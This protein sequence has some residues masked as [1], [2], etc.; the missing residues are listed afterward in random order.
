MRRERWTGQFLTGLAALVACTHWATAQAPVS[1]KPAAVVNGEAI[2]MSDVQILLDQRPSAVTLTE[3]Q[4]KQMRQSALN[5]IIDDLL[6]RQFLKVNA[7]PATPAEVQKELGDL[8]TALQQQKM[9]FQEFLKQN[10][11]TEQQL[12]ADIA[13]KVQWKKYLQRSFS[14]AQMKQYY[15]ANKI[16]FDK[17]FVRASH[18]LIRVSSNATQ[19][20]RAAAEQQ[21][22]GI[23][24]QILANQ[25]SF[26]DAAK[27]HSTCP[28][29]DKGGDI[30]HFPYKF[31]VVEPFARAA[32]SL[33]VGQ[34]SDVVAT[35]FGLHIIQVTE[36]LPGEPS[37]FDNMKETVREVYAQDANLFQQV[38]AQQRK[39]ANI[40]VFMQ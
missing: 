7:A 40:Q 30:G 16:F 18:I 37:N 35:D 3:E 26:A 15:D 28:T 29:K 10:G 6:M 32:F 14:D 31:V 2:P 21:L 12:R 5:V 39:T 27:K 4:K 23:R 20:E 17:V 24:Q 22:Q 36:R 13:A 25:I 33:K 1:S 8:V 34:I 19:Q 38:L 9:T 11:Q